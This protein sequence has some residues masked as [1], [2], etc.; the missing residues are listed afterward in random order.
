MSEIFDDPA[1]ARYLRSESPASF[2][3]A[4]RLWRT[5]MAAEH[6]S[7]R[8]KELVLLAV[9]ASASAVNAQAI[10]RHTKRA[11]AAGASDGDVLD[12]LVSIVGLSNHSMYFSLP[13]LQDELRKAGRGEEAEPPE[14]LPDLEAVRDD[15]LK[16]RGFWSE[17][18]DTIAQFL[19]AYSRALSELTMV[20]WKQGA[21]TPKEREFIYIAIDCSVTHMYGPG[22]AMHIRHALEHGATRDEIL[23]VFQLAVLIGLEGYILGAEA[24][25]K[26]G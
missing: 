5:V 19:P 22:L 7:V 13:I 10:G 26:L 11:R 6:L 21:L 25:Q 14:M 4:S 18:R 8:M 15:F 24:L 20:P 3:A 16:T 17:Q 23:T 2:E 9:H 12:V 1:V